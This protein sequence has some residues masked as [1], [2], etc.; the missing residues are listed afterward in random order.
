M[1][2]RTARRA[3]YAKYFDVDWDPPEA[4]LRDIVL[5][6]ILGDHYGRVLEAGELQ[7]ERRGGS[8]TLSYHDHRVPIAPRSLGGLVV[9]AGRRADSDDLIFIGGALGRLPTAAD[10]DRESVERRHRDKEVLRRQLARITLEQPELGRAL[11]A[12]VEATNA[13]PDA[14]HAILEEQHYRLANWRAAG[15]DLGYRR[16]F[17]VTSLIGIRV[18]DP[19]VFADTHLVPMRWIRDGVIDGLRVDH[20][21]GLR[22]PATY[23]RRLREASP[24]GWIV[25]EKILEGDESAA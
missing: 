5:L 11:D 19:D 7:L 4:Y 1:S 22:D 21:D 18:E 6:P 24:R 20:P 3:R 15:H 8:F 12:E 10:V 25:A 17:D 16:F 23:F 9:A 13:D 14:L 2:S